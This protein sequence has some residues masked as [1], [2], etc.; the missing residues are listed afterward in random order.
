M[1]ARILTADAHTVVTDFLSDYVKGQ[2]SSPYPTKTAESIGQM[3]AGEKIANYYRVDIPEP[4]R[5]LMA[6]E[7][8]LGI[9]TDRPAV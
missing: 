3:L 8:L 4:G 5:S 6:R 7:Y 9:L 2:L 1:Q